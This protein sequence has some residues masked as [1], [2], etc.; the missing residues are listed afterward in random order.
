MSPHP[1]NQPTHGPNARV[2]QVKEVPASGMRLLSSR[3]PNA[4]SSIG[5]NPMRMI[6][7]ICAPTTDA[8]GPI[9]AVNV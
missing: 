4:T 9:A 7:G 1:A 6:A 8:V 5:M 2:A 3:Y